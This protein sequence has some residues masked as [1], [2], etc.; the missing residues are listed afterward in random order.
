MPGVRGRY[1]KELAEWFDA[2]TD[3]VECYAEVLN[4]WAAPESHQ[5]RPWLPEAAENAETPPTED[6]K[7]IPDRALSRR[8]GTLPAIAF[9][10]SIAGRKARCVVQVAGSELPIDLPVRLL[11]A[12]GLKPGDRFLWWMSE[13]GSV[14]A[15]DIDDLPPNRLTAAEEQEAQRLYQEHCEDVASGDPWGFGAG[16]G[17]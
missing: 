10:E 2:P 5:E 9:V 14:A 6:F 4:S 13:D 11:D 8:A 15:E 12:R 17:R 1:A 16:K 7:V 3:A